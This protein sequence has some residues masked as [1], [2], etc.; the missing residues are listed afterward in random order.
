MGVLIVFK[1]KALLMILFVLILTFS[2]SI[3]GCEDDQDCENCSCCNI[4]G[5][6]G[7]GPCTDCTCC[8]AGCCPMEN[9]FCCPDWYCAA[10]P[11]DC[12]YQHKRR[13]LLTSS[14]W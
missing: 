8:P 13:D 9:W 5:G 14:V 10:T 3:S 1:M 7:G 11:A 2:Y 6:V 12:A 4:N